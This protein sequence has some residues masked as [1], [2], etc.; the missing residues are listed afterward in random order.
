VEPLN[1]GE[2]NLVNTVIEGAEAAAQADHP[3]VRL[4]VDIFHMLRNGESPDDIIK[5]G[6]QVRHAHVAE[7]AERTAP[8]VRGDDFRPYLRALKRAGYAGMLTIECNWGN[9]GPEVGPAIGALRAQLADAG[10]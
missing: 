1:R 2:C 9:L 10:Y 5:V 6:A 8:G 4:L 7:M 3:S